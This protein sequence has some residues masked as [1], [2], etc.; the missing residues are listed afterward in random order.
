MMIKDELEKIKELQA[1]IIELKN[2]KENLDN[3]IQDTNHDIERTIEVLE[4]CKLTK[5][6]KKDFDAVRQSHFA[7][8]N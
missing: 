4:P 1:Q 3:K 7:R 8:L 2:Q 6:Q 5:T